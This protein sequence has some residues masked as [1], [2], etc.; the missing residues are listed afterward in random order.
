MKVHIHTLF[1]PTRGSISKNS[2]TVQISVLPNQRSKHK[3]SSL[4]AYYYFFENNGNH[5]RIFI[6]IFYTLRGGIFKRVKEVC[7]I[8]YTIA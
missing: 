8:F 5:K 6:S 4:S 1:H 2:E 7:I 3:T